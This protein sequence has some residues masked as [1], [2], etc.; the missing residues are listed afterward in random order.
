VESI[1]PENESFDYIPCSHSNGNVVCDEAPLKEVQKVFERTSS[2]RLASVQL[3]LQPY[4]FT[5]TY[6]PTD[7]FGT[8]RIL[9][10]WIGF[11]LGSCC[12]NKLEI[13]ANAFRSTKSYTTG[14]TINVIDCTQLDFGFLS[15]FDKLTKLVFDNI[16]N[17]QHC[18]SSLPPLPRLTTLHFANCFGMNE[19][20]NFP[21]LTKGLK[22]VEFSNDDFS[23]FHLYRDINDETIDRVMTWLLL[24][25]ANTLEE[26]AIFGMN[27]VTRVPQKIAEFKALRQLWLH[28]SNISIIQSGAFSFSVPVS[29]VSIIGNGIKEIKQGAFH[30]KHNNA[31]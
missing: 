10:V 18:L 19:L 24:S 27:Q 1:K 15:G 25:S 28:D 7:V 5:E 12:D 9:D 23:S 29:I 2:P 3:T 16:Y 30:G 17:I 22:D 14:F 20:H 31:V 6:I 4:I 26:M 13:D 21:V 11:P 8:K